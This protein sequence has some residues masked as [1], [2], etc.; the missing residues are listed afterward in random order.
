M[1]EY[2]KEDNDEAAVTEERNKR[3]SE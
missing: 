2:I 1:M 3:R